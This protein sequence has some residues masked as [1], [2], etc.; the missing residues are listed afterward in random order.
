MTESRDE[1]SI[2]FSHS[3]YITCVES[4]WKSFEVRLTLVC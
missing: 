3:L 1:Q 4:S 2:R